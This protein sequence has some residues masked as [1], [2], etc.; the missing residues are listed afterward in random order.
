MDNWIILALSSALLLALVNLIDRLTVT[1]EIKHPIY[2]FG[3][4]SASGGAVF[5]ITS[6]ILTK[7]LVLPQ[8]NISLNGIAIGL[9]LSLAILVYL[10]S[11]QKE[12]AS[13][14]APIF[15]LTPLFVLIMAILFL[16]ANFN[17]PIYLGFFLIISGI[18]ILSK[19]RLKKIKINQGVS[20]AL[21]AAFLFA[22]SSI[23]IS[24]AINSN[25]LSSLFFWIGLGRILASLSFLL[26]Y[27]KKINHRSDKTLFHIIFAGIIGAFSFVF[28]ILAA[29][30]KSIT[31]ASFI[32]E[33]YPVLV[34]IL[35]IIF[36][37]FTRKPLEKIK[38]SSFILKI[39]ATIL[40]IIG[41][42]LIL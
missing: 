37:R 17:L 18:L 29:D 20:L 41:T 27:F 42:L 33:T 2:Y 5:I 21:L 14:L 6:L 39:L 4:S 31:H 10:Y 34:I 11:L 1:R 16:G 40:I 28:F 26:Y 15:S 24:P 38:K 8:F 3:V 22:L 7:G 32:S 12:E 30:L 25:Y 23:L 19:P 36:N 13:R 35:I 9:I